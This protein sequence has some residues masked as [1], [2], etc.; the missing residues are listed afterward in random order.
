MP[1][2]ALD[3]DEVVSSEDSL[4]VAELVAELVAE[5]LAAVLAGVAVPPELQPT[6]IRD[7]TAMPETLESKALRLIGCSL[8]RWSDRSPVRDPLWTGP[9]SGS[10]RQP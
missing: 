4:D 6:R 9:L 2:A 5:V 1:V 10:S 7:A 3:A 8:V